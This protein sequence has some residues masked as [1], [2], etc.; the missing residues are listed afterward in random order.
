MLHALSYRPV[1]KY[2]ERGAQKHVWIDEGGRNKSGENYLTRKF[3]ECCKINYF[4]RMR[5]AG[6]KEL[7]INK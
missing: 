5:Q 1:E 3:T 4:R 2:F 7:G 6:P